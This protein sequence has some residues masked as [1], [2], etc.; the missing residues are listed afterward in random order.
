MRDDWPELRDMGIALLQSVHWYGP[1][2]VEFRI[3]PRD[4]RRQTNQQQRDVLFHHPFR[5]CVPLPGESTPRKRR[6][7]RGC[8][9][10]L[11]AS[12]AP[13]E[14][15]GSEI[16]SNTSTQP[17]LRKF[18]LTTENERIFSMSERTFSKAKVHS[19]STD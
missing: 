12:H 2:Q 4:G 8:P 5:T 19:R 10:I 11:G 17:A 13:P 1:A 9:L 14:S 7:A 16:A 6:G 15:L 18:D 3:D